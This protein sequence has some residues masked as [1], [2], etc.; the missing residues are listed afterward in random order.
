MR[1]AIIVSVSPDKQL[2]L[3]PDIQEKLIPGDE[4]LLWENDDSIMFKKVQKMLTL[5]NL[6]QKVKALGKDE[7]WMSEEEVTEV[8]KQLKNKKKQEVN[9]GSC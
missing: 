3:P 4:Y 5:D 6:Q 9:E 2:E 1:Q 7:T 8:I